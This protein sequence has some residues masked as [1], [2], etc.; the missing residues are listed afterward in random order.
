[1]K[2]AIGTANFNQKY[3]VSKSFVS[4][5]KSFKK[6]FKIIKDHKIEYLDTAFNYKHVS[7]L[8]GKKNI[9]KIK[10]IT[11]I[12]LPNKNKLFFINNLEK[13][14][15]LKLLKIN[16]RSFEAILLHNIHDLKSLYANRLIQKIKLLKKNKYVR[17]IGVSIYDPN[18]LRIVFSKFN[19]EIVQVPIN[20]L[21]NRIIKSQ[22]FDILKKRRIIIQA[23][24]IF[25]QGLLIKK[26]SLIKKKNLN[27]ELLIKIKKLD[28]WCKLNKISRLEACLNFVKTVKGINITTIGISSSKELLEILNIIKKNKKIQFQDFSTSNLKIIDPRKW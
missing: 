7:E 6:I 11:K 23:R 15:K 12:R 4:A 25:L 3:G 2:I 20:I 1:M 19:P 28:S 13:I 27:K 16:S 24:S 17:K 5:T 21:D 26:I 8:T 9:N 18:D 22:W 10:V 14:V